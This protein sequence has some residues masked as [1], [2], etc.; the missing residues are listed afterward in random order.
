MQPGQPMY[1]PGAQGGYPGPAGRGMPQMGMRGYP[2]PM[3]G[4]FPGQMPNMPPM[5]YPQGYPAYPGGGRGVS[6]IERF[7]FS[8]TNL[9]FYVGHASSDA[10]HAARSTALPWHGA[11]RWPNGWHAY[12]RTA[13]DAASRSWPDASCCWWCS[14][15]C[16]SLCCSSSSRS[17]CTERSQHHSRCFGQRRTCRTK[18]DARRSSL[19]SYPRDRTF[20]GWKGTRRQLVC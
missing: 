8:S 4:R 14:S 6:N 9:H 10:R 17:S 7:I 20:I 16:R 15:T 19:S 18:A 13:T 3:Q 5:P 1:Y 2:Q 12:A 11:E